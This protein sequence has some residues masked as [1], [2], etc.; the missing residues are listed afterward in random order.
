MTVNLHP[1]RTKEQLTPGFPTLVPVITGEVTFKELIHI[2]QH[3]KICAQKMETNYDAQN[4]L[5]IVLPVPLWPYFSTCQYPSP[6]VNPGMNPSYDGRLDATTNTTIRDKWQLNNK[7]YEEH[8]HINSA[9]VG[10]FLKLIPQS[11]LTGL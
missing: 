1:V 3:C 2:W 10:R 9:L 11:K 7:N 4:F 8:K 6:P 5:Y